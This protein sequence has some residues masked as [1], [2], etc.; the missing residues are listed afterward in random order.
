M[1][2]PPTRALAA[3]LAIALTAL[4][5]A[6][7]C[8]H[9]APQ[10]PASTAGQ[11]PASGA[12]TAASRK[13]PAASFETVRAVLQSTRCVNCHPAGD[14]PLQGDDSHVHLQNVQRG[15]EGRGVPGFG[16]ATCHGK[17]NPPDSYGEHEPP[18][19]ATEWHLP[20]AHTRMVFEGLRSRA[21]CEQLKDPQRN[22]G[23][24]LPALVHHVSDDPL[25]LWGWSPGYGRKPVPIAHAEFVS[26]FKAWADGGA[27]CP[28]Q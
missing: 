25:V 2:G 12:S 4:T 21:L 28:A 1:N 15:F 19:V 7:A 24:D 3:L 9:G 10:A 23:K 22:G 11:A 18:G 6:A 16:C 17:A 20:P 27:P 5:L 8:S 14:A 26:A 13:D